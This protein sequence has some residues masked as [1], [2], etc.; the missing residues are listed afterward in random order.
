MNVSQDEKLQLKVDDVVWREVGDELVVLELSTSTYLTLNGTAKYL[1][2]SLADG[3][4]LDRLIEM[5][6][7]RYQISNHQA[8]S[9]TES[10]LSALADRELIVHDA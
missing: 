2:E 5:L 8:R 6:V 9:D 7:E 10:F 3:A 4:T 1:W